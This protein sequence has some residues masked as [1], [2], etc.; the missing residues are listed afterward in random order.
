MKKKIALALI[1]MSTVGLFGCGN[2]QVDITEEEILDTEELL[3]NTDAPE[4]VSGV[5]QT[6]YIP[7]SFVEESA[8][9]NAFESY[10]EV[11]S[12]LQP[13]Q[14]YAYI[15]MY[16]YDGK[17]LLVTE[18]TFVDADGKTVAMQAG[19]YAL[20]EDEVWYVKAV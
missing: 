17:V 4:D 19:A 11:I 14:A 6:D 12:F 10:D 7:N 13:G 1:V 16:G 15:E 5:E 9:K 8:G 2:K 18:N 3:Q 20:I